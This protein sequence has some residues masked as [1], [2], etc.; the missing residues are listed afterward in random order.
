MNIVIIDVGSN[1]EP[2]Y[3]ISQANRLIAQEHTFLLASS[4]T[5]T[6]A[7]GDVPQPDYLNCAFKVG[8]FYHEENFNLFLKKVESQLGRI[9]SKDKF[10]PRTIDLDIIAWNG[11]VV[12]KDFYQRY[13]VR[14][15]ALEL[16][17]DLIY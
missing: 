9:R 2:E 16:D 4:I 3:N 6:K 1:I 10:T 17:P 7:I 5:R 12:H 8:T 14:K 11:K 13:F 15:Y